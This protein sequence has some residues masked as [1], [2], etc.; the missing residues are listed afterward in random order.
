M[1]HRGGTS[2]VNKCKHEE[3]QACICSIVAYEPDESCP[4]HGGGI[5]PPRCQN[6]G[7]FMKRKRVRP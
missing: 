6:C 5:W 2:K 1:T 4:R 7:K 3:S